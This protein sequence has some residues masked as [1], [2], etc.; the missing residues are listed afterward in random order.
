[1]RLGK[2]GVIQQEAT[3][4]NRIKKRR[5]LMCGR[6]FL[7]YSR[8]ILLGG[9]DAEEYRAGVVSDTGCGGDFD[10]KI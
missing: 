6:L 7:V 8:R 1:M 9:F 10:V 4:D 5:Q 3:L 2:E